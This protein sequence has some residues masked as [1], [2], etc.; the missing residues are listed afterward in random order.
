[1]KKLI[2]I[3]VFGI[4]LLSSLRVGALQVIKEK[5]ILQVNEEYDLVIIAPNIFSS[6]LQPLLDHKNS[7]N[8]RSVLKTTEDIY[9]DYNGRDQPEQIKYFIKDAIETW[10]IDYVMLVG[11]AELL[12]SRYTHIYFVYDYQIQ[13][14]FLSDLYYA[15]I[16]DENDNFC[17][18]DSNNNDIFGEHKWDGKTDDIDLI[19]DV[20]IGRLAQYVQIR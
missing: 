14:E 13:W 3:I 8:V 15:D 1:M 7:R 16:Y 11:G 5:P 4:F 19:P 9:N 17:T 6:V 2:S 12:P 18:W 10:G 20:Y